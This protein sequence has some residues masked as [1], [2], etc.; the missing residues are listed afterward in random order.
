MHMIK[1]IKNGRLINGDCLKELKH[2]PSDCIDLVITDPPYGLS[3][4]CLGWDK[5]VPGLAVWQECLRVLKPGGFIFVMSAVRQDVLSRMI[6]NLTDAGF[7][8]Q[9]TSLYWTYSLFNWISKSK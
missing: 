3:F 8:T 7:N 6:V 9:F 5:K 4:Y 1:E 2:Y